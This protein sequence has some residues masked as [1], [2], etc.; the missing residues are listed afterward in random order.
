MRGSV[1]GT[2]HVRQGVPEPRRAKASPARLRVFATGTATVGSLPAAARL[3]QAPVRPRVPFTYVAPLAVAR[4]G[5]KAASI[6]VRPL[7]SPR[8]ICRATSL[9]VSVPAPRVS[10]QAAIHLRG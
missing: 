3:R 6:L 1:Q 7:P 5:H 8:S 2:V 4:P 10:K 9:E